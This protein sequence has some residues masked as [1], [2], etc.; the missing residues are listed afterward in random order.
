[1]R[2]GE[3]A[4]SSG[5]SARSLRFYEDQGLIVPGRRSN[6]YRDYCASTVEQVVLIRSLLDSGLPLRLV[7]DFL[8]CTA[9]AS[10]GR[11]ELGR[12]DLLADLRRYRDRLEGRIGSLS[13][14]LAALDEFLRDARSHDR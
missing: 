6:G 11:P 5:V 10:G 13:A 9:D 3:A 2:I 1:M 7:R 4:K 12:P 14:R 8:P